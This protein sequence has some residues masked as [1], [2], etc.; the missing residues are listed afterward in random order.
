VRGRD[1]RKELEERE[2]VATR[3]KSRSHSHSQQESVQYDIHHRICNIIMSL[4][5]V[6]LH[7]SAVPL[8]I[9]AGSAAISGSKRARTEQIST[10]N[11]D[12]DDPLDD[13]DSDASDSDEDDTAQLLAELNRIKKERAQE[14][15]KKA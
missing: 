6:S 15:S 14:N 2:K 13:D 8:A 10:A 4:C 3:E 12:A 9:A 11:L 1:F 7:R 5:G